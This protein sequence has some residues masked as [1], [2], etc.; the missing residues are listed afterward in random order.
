MGRKRS[1]T[2]SGQELVEFALILPLLLLLLLGII[3]FGITVFAYN[4]V[5]NVGREIARYGAVHADI[6]LIDQYITDTL[7]S[8]AWTTGIF[9]ESLQITPTLTSGAA[10]ESRVEVSVSYEHRLLSG[11]VI[12]AVGGNPILTLRSVSSMRTE[13]F[14]RDD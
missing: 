10:Y 12:R 2:E 14:V 13:Q 8:Q 9:T 1:F 11:P 5:A 7:Q 3:E 4:T 6:T